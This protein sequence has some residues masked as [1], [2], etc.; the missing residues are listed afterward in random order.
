MTKTT[1]IQHPEQGRVEGVTYKKIKLLDPE[2]QAI[3]HGDCAVEGWMSQDKGCL[4]LKSGGWSEVLVKRD[5]TGDINN[6]FDVKYHFSNDSGH[7]YESSFIINKSDKRFAPKL[8][9]RKAQAVVLPE[10]M[11]WEDLWKHITQ[12]SPKV[13]WDYLKDAA[14]TVIQVWQEESDGTNQTA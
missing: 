1:I 13:Y 8:E 4:Y 11:T 3:F 10:G 6:I 14:T 5:V 7:C 12:G 9:G 2:A